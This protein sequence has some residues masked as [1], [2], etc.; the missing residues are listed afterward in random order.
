MGVYRGLRCVGG[1]NQ[2]V[3]KDLDGHI[4]VLRD[5]EQYVKIDREA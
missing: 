3:N 5:I 1:H 4:R 2:G